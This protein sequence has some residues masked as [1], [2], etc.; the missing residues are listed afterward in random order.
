MKSQATYGLVP[1]NS[2]DSYFQ[3][4][5]RKTQGEEYDIIVV[6]GE[7]THWRCD[8]LLWAVE[9]IV[10]GGK[11]IADNWRQPNVWPADEGHNDFCWCGPM[12]EKHFPEM[13]K[14]QHPSYHNKPAHTNGWQTIIFQVDHP[15]KVTH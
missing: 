4:L 15:H 8:V 5:N 11:I 1:S 14:Y 12:I 13:Q 7:P 2:M 10:A 9:H 6:D 3:E